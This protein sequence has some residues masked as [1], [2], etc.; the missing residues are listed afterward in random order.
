M[1]RTECWT[2]S[3]EKALGGTINVHASFRRICRHSY[4]SL[5]LLFIVILTYVDSIYAIGNESS[6]RVQTKP[7]SSKIV[8]P[9]T[10]HDVG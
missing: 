2:S 1:S 3:C 6:R 8:E 10:L 5:L 4:L 7:T 9:T